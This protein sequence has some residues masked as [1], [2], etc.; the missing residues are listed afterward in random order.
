MP[1]R[2]STGKVEA[3]SFDIGPTPESEPEPLSVPDVNAV[4]SSS[5]ISSVAGGVVVVAA[6]EALA[7]PADS[8]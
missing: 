4:A 6:A 8:L 3:S 2:A 1:T 7:D 5:R